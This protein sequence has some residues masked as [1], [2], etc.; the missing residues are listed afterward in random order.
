MIAPTDAGV[1]IT[2]ESGTGKELI[3]SPM[4]CISGAIEAC[5]A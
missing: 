1:L 2:G 3:S 4:I 5:G